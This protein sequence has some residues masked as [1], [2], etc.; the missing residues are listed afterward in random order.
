MGLFGKSFDEKVKDALDKIS[1]LGLGVRNLSAKI[2]GKT[3]TLT[4]DAPSREIT[5]QVMENFDKLVKTD[6]TLNAIRVDAPK[7][8][9]APVPPPAPKPAERFYE[10]VAGDTLSKI[11]LKYYGSAN[12]Y[13]KIFEANRDILNNPDLIKPGQK[14]RIPE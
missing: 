2:E 5:V 9:P 8:A 11:A 6:N 12:K 13:M 4:G 14:L 3:V 7:P 10:V 1:G